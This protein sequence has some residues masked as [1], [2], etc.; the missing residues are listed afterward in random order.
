[1]LRIY[2]L[3]SDT[4]IETGQAVFPCRLEACDPRQPY[5]VLRDT[6]RFLTLE[7]DQ[8]EDLNADRDYDDLLVQ[9][10]NVRVA[11][12]PAAAALRQAARCAPRCAPR[13]CLPRR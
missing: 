11:S 1:M 12:R 5:R 2:D 4:L 13:R 9:T 6:V 10:Y 8:D 3:A 7:A